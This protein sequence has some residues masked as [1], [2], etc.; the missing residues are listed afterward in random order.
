MTIPSH[1]HTVPPTHD[2]RQAPVAP[3]HGGGVRTGGVSKPKDAHYDPAGNPIE[4]GSSS[5]RD[6]QAGGDM[7]GR[8]SDTRD[9]NFIVDGGAGPNRQLQRDIGAGV[10][11]FD[12]SAPSRQPLS[13]IEPDGSEDPLSGIDNGLLGVKAEGVKD[14]S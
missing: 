7:S 6:Q 8:A 11:D 4:F 9:D 12:Q 3:A 13:S 1:P 10:D 5:V 14:K 2:P